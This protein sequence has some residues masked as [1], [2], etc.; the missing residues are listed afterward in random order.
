MVVQTWSFRYLQL[1]M[2]R[3]KTQ[4]QLKEELITTLSNGHDGNA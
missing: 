1:Q 2:L 3:R 4:T